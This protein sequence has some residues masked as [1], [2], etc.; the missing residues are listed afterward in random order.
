[1][2][3]KKLCA[4]TKARVRCAQLIDMA[5]ERGLVVTSVEDITCYRAGNFEVP[6]FLE[7]EG[8]SPPPQQQQQ[9]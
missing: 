4:L 3:E 7:R 6:S 5:K 1:M 8:V 9:Q 2:C